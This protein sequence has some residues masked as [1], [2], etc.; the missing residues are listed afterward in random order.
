LIPFDYHTHHERCGHARGTIEE[1]VQAALAL[2]LREIGISDHAPIYWREGDHAQPGS[3]MARSTLPAYV[4]EVLALKK[5]YDGRIRVLLGLESDYAPGFEEVY[6][7]LLGSYP[8]DYVIGSVHYVGSWHIYQREQ[9][10]THA[11]PD[12]AY[13]EY[14]RLIRE[15][16]RSG[17]FDVLG[18]ITGYLTF[19]P[20]PTAAVRE[21]EFAE[22]ARVLAETGVA[23]EV[24][25]SGLRKGT[26]HPFPAADLL[27]A[28]LDS[29]VPVTYGS[30]A[31]RPDEVS[32]ARDVAAP[33]IEGARLWTPT[34]N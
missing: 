9:W 32:H 3:A 13:A 23:I 16:A 19:G 6:R 15:S 34:R 4:D 27:R 30:D 7:D 31:H 22:T 17:L 12:A 21:R 1:Y 20:G 10:S 33:L 28:C 2:G 18:H 29:G 8:F 11:D 26:G 5:R 24:N 14:F 25:T